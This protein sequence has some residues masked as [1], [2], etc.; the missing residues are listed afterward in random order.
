MKLYLISQSQNDHCDTYDS[1][2]VAA[3]NEDT[4]RWM[5]PGGYD[6]DI[7]FT[8]WGKTGSGWALK[9]EDVKVEY[10]GEAVEGTELGVI[11]ASFNPC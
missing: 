8:R 9:P 11:C 6:G 10:L 3:P 1:A 2:V 4:A 7:F 5:D